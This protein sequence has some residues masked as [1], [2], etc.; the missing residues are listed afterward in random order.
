[1]G[2]IIEFVPTTASV[3][4]SMIQERPSQTVN[5]IWGNREPKLY[6]SSNIKSILEYPYFYINQILVWTQQFL[7]F[8]C[9]ENSNY[10]HVLTMTILKRGP[11]NYFSKAVE[12]FST[13]MTVQTTKKKGTRFSFQFL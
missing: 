4:G 6:I 3:F 1:M 11:Q 9:P 8:Q 12:I 2:S 13:T 10:V 5:I 7:Q